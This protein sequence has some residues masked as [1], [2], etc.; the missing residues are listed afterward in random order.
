MIYQ[1]KMQRDIAGTAIC[2]VGLSLA[3]IGFFILAGK[4]NLSAVLGTII[5]STTSILNYSLRVLIMHSAAKYN[6]KK[7]TLILRLSKVSRTLFIGAIAFIIFLFPLFHDVTGIVALFF[8]QISRS[9]ISR[10]KD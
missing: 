6:Y 8:S 5:G 10:M 1:Q 4:C 3:M 2:V 7:A 9:I